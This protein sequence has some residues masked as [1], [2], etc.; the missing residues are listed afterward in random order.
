MNDTPVWDDATLSLDSL[1]RID[2]VC[3][4]FEDAWQAGRRPRAEQ[5]VAEVPQSERPALLRQLLPLELEYRQQ[6]GETPTKE[7]CLARFPDHGALVEEVFCRRS[8]A[9]VA[10]SPGAKVR[11]FGDYELLGEIA[12]GGMGVVYRARQMSLCRIVAL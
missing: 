1:E 8:T 3:L 6:D 5:Y 11:Y 12:R 2:K 9:A 4:A 7:E 10:P